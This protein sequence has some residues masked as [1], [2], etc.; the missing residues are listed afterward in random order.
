MQK[1]LIQRLQELSYKVTQYVDIV[2]RQ[3]HHL[4]GGAARASRY[5]NHDAPAILFTT[6][7]TEY[8][9]YS[10]KIVQY[11]VITA[12]LITL[13]SSIINQ[14]NND[15]WICYK[16]C[17]TLTVVTRLPTVFSQLIYQ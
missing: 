14:Y 10:T 13:N 12:S 3:T 16:M 6:L 15:S 1:T 11:E 5:V 7:I 2:E 4:R 8:R 17:C 9:G